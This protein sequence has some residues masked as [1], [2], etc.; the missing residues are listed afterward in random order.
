[1]R[2]NFTR[3][4]ANPRE[5]ER[6]ASSARLPAASVSC[7]ISYAALG[8]VTIVSELV[9]RTCRSRRWIV[10]AIE[11]RPA[12]DRAARR[13]IPRRG[14]RRSIDGSNR[15]R[16]RESP[17]RLIMEN[18]RHIDRRIDSNVAERWAS[19]GSRSRGMIQPMVSK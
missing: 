7:A 12:H 18:S 5:R 17:R 8:D 4:P 9:S 15:E 2:K 13:P 16:S 11:D 19:F 1:M 6:F 3:E 10:P 14:I